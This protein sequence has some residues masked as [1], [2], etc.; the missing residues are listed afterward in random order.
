MSRPLENSPTPRFSAGMRSANRRPLTAAAA[1]LVIGLFCASV[2]F[3]DVAP[4]FGKVV[5]LLDDSFVSGPA[6]AVT[7][8]PIAPGRWSGDDSEVVSEPRG[9]KPE[10]GQKMLRLLRADCEGKA[11]P[12]ESHVADFYRWID[13]RPC[14]HE[15]ADGSVLVQLSAA[16]N[17]G[18]FRDGEIYSSRMT[19]HAVD[20]ETVT[21]GALRIVSARDEHGLATAS[22]GPARRDRDSSTWQRRSSDSRVPFNTDFRLIH[23]IISPGRGNYL[24]A[25]FF[26]D[27]VDDV[28][29]TM[30][31]NPLS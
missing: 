4:S 23:L 18:E 29:L 15:F 30:R 24:E 1:G 7:G 10:S 14:R 5:T 25:G 16:L 21:N 31:H 26:G 2:V 3:A 6:P 22:T 27:Y 20:A 28:G 12:N 8:V 13:V 9:V 17:A 11:N 19:C